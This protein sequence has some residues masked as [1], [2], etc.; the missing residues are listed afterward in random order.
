ML[1]IE[2]ISKRLNDR[3]LT[4]VSKAT[5]ISYPTIW[6][7]ANGQAGNVGYNTVKKLSEYLEAAA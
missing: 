3:T 4:K 1:A 6:K 5:G 7:I 2:E